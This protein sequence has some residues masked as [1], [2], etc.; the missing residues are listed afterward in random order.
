MSGGLISTYNRATCQWYPGAQTEMKNL[1]LD[2]L[3][4]RDLDHD[5]VLSPYEDHRLSADIRAKDLLSRMTLAEKAGVMMHGTAQTNGPIGIMGV[6]S[7]YNL[8]ANRQA[9]AERKINHLITRLDNDPQA[10][11]QQNNLLQRIASETRLGI[12][13]TIS[14]DPRHHFQHVTGAS[15]R[16]KGF[17]QWPETTGLA[18]VGSAELVQ[19]FAEIARA[20]YRAVGIHMALSPQADIATEPRWP[21]ISGTFGE[22]PAL[23][24]KLVGAYVKGMQAGTTGLQHNSV[25]CVVK[26][27]VG[28]GAAPEGFDG[29]NAYG[30]Y[31]ELTEASLRLHIEPFLTSFEHNVAGV[32]PTYT[33]LKDLVHKGE[34]L[35]Q[36]AGGFSKELIDGLLRTEYQF[37]GFVLSDWA[38]FRDAG[39][40]TFNPTQMQSPNQIAMPWGVESLARA[41]RFAKAINAGC[42]QLGGEEDV[43]ILLAVIDQGLV[44][45]KR[46]DEA[47]YR[48]LVQKFEQGLFE[49]P[50]VDEA[51]A[52][53]LV[54][55]A[56]AV[57]TGRDAQ[58]RSLI[59]LKKPTSI[60]P[61]SKFYFENIDTASAHN[62]AEGTADIAIIRLSTPHQQLHQNFFFGSRQ[63]E[64]DIDFKAEGEDTQRLQALSKLMPTIAVIQMS[65]PAVI[66]DIIDGLDGLYVDLGV[67][68]DLLIDAIVERQDT[69]GTL[70]FELPCSMQAVMDQRPD[71]PSDSH[72]PTFTIGSDYRDK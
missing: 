18:A 48:M 55:S 25:S 9:I 1:K 64:G 11:A 43:A 46:I 26:H 21:R 63:Q 50:F 5:G 60:L 4:F 58:R 42:D 2:G 12:P 6:G 45:H 36:V 3:T 57:N 47:V 38:I 10:F 13:V 22:D 54:G 27:W 52:E 8:E 14:T 24:R 62:T 68:D 53:A 65:R 29:H 70:P 44:E 37:K 40:Q 56:Q 28:Y 66:A 67:S 35:E 31:S 69:E 30:R 34:L 17:S 16:A 15:S 61:D 72:D 7:E 19:Q 49:N 51:L 71:L 23:A 20:E 41:E 32:M 39:E 33:I 59:C